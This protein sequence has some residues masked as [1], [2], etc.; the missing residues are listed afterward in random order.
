MF[1]NIIITGDDFGIPLLLK[2]LPPEKVKAFLVSSVRP[3]Y[4]EQLKETARQHK[5][6]FFIQPKY[7]TNEYS[8][9]LSALQKK[10]FDLL[11]CCS[12]SMI[13]RKDILALVKKKKN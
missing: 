9:F 10:E 13:L 6:D 8:Q 11:L 2:T 5:I 4:I 12:Y 1:Q 3:Q 7:N